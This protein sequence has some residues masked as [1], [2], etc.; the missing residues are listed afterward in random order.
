MDRVR[1]AF[2]NSLYQFVRSAENFA[3]FLIYN[4]PS[5]IVLLIVFFII[6]LIL[7]GILRRL[8]G[9]SKKNISPKAHE[10]QK[11][12]PKEDNKE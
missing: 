7:R 8:F 3:I 6:F 5:L 10:P 9:K 12:E 11:E 4:G 1:N 2:D